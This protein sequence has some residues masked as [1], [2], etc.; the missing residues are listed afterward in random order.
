VAGDDDEEPLSSRL[1]LLLLRL[2]LVARAADWRS[3]STGARVGLEKA[4]LR[5]GCAMA[6]A[7]V[8]PWVLPR[9]V[10]RL[11]ARI[12]DYERGIEGKGVRCE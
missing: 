6:M 2:R 10:L 9:G 5:S 4:W 1:L 3:S 7:M 11:V 12:E 8:V